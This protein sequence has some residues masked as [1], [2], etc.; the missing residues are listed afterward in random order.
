MYKNG[1]FRV[2]DGLAYNAVSMLRVSAEERNWEV[3]MASCLSY[4]LEVN[5]YC[6]HKS[7]I[8]IS[9]IYTQNNKQYYN[10]TSSTA[11]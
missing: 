10:E 3:R 9:L 11:I 5:S 6:Q 4:D 1:S 2:L 8:S 7:R